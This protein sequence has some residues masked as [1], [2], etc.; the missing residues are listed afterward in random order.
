MSTLTAC[1][2]KAGKNISR[3][4]REL[5]L[6]KTQEYRQQGMTWQPAAERAIDDAIERVQALIR[7]SRE[8]ATQEPEAAPPVAAPAPEKAKPEVSANKV[9]TDDAAARARA[10]LKSKLSTPMGGIDPEILQAGIVLA[11]YHIEKGARTFAAYARAMLDDMGEGI[12]PYLKQFYMATKYDPRAGDIAKEMSSA[13]FVEEFD[14]AAIAAP[15]TAEPEQ[16]GAQDGTATRDL[17]SAGTAE[18]AGQPAADVRAPAG[19]RDAG[20]VA[21]GSG[22]GTEPRDADADA[23]GDDLGGSLGTGEPGAVSGERGAGGR[24]A[25]ERGLQGAPRADSGNERADDAGREAGLGRAGHRLQGAVRQEDAPE[26]GLAQPAAAPNAAPIAPPQITP[27][28][29]QDFT[30]G[31]D[32]ELGEGGQKTKFRANLAA[33][34]LAK[35]LRENPERPITADDQRT[36]AKYVGWGGLPQAFDANNPDWRKEHAELKAALTPE[37]FEDARRSTRYAHY[38]SREII[39]DGVYAAL[40]HFGF[41]GGRVLEPGAGVGNFIGMMPADMRTAG[42][43]TAI[44]REPIAVTIAKHLYPQQNVQEA[45]FTQF[46]GNDGY[47][48]AVVGNPPFASDTQVD[49]SRRK[50]LSGLNLHSYFF[51][52][53]VDMM[54]EGGVLAQVVTNYFLDTTGDKARK[55][56]ADRTKFLGAIRLP[57]NAFSKNAGT[58]VTTD[59]IFLQKRP[60]SEWGSK[61]AKDEAK[62]W[63]D[64][65]PYQGEGGDAVPL[66]TYFHEHPEMMLG[67]FGGYGTM[68]RKGSP[69]LIAREGQDTL[70]LLKEAVAKLPAGVYKSI[71]ETGSA[72]AIDRAVVAL[73]KP[74][75]QEGGYFVKDGK[76]MQ[77]LQDLAGEARGVELTADTQWTEKTK[78]GERRLEQIRQLADL[79]Q[80]L[81]DLL[82]AELKGD[83]RME[84]LR[85]TLNAQYDAYR[86]DHGLLGD[87]A[88]YQVFDDDPD[89]PLL[90]SLEHKYAAGI[91]PADAKKLGIKPTKSTAEKA[92]IF[93]RRVVEAREQVRKVESPKDALAVSMAERGRLDT[94]YI[95]ELLGKD[96]QDV[97]QEMTQ[98][99][100][101]LLFM[102]PATNEYVLRDAYLSGNVRAKLAQAKAAAMTV[103]ARELEKV[104]PEDVPAHQIAARIGAPWVPT[105]VYENFAKDLFGEGTKASITY[106]QLNSSYGVYVTAGSEVN[107]S[108]K[109]GIPAYS[110]PELLAALLNNRT[111]KVTYK[112]T[113]GKTHTDVEKTEMANQKAQEIKDRFNDWLM[114]DPDR[115][116]LLTRAY[117]DTNNNY[118]T[119]TYDGS[120]MTFPGKVPDS[121]VKFRRHQRNAIARIVQDRTVLLDH[122]VGAGKTFEIVAAAMELKRT[123]LANKPLVAVPN[124]LVKQWAADF[125]RLYPGANILTATKKDFERVN[126]RRFLAKI[127]TG[128]WDAVVIAHSSF[129][130]IQPGADF[131][132]AFNQKQIELIAAAIQEVEESDADDKAKKRTVK[133]LE[134]MME[135]LEKR[136]QRLRD[137]PMD[138]LLDFHELG[139]DQLFVDEAHMFKNLMYQTKLQNVAGLGDP[140]GSKRAYDMYVKTQEVMEKNGRGQGLVFATG[141]PVSNSLAEKYHMMRYLMPEQMEELGFQSFDAWANT[142]ADVRQHWMQ[143]VSGDGFKA[144]NRMSEFVNVHELLKLFDQVADT[145]TN[146]DIK[147]AYREEN[148]GAEY[149]LPPIKGGK[150]RAPVSLDKSPRQEA[151]MVQLAARAA[152]VEARKGPPQKG[153]DN[154]LSLMTDARKA[155]MDIRLVDLDVTEREKG[156]RIDKSAGEIAA[157]Y[158]QWDHVKGTQLVFSDLGTP[159]KHAEKELKEYQRLQAIVAE[160]SDEVRDRAA[161]GD[162]RAQEI[163]NAAEDAE[164]ELDEQGPDWIT[165]V[166]AA[167]RGFSVYDDLKDALVE[168]GIPEGQIAFIHDYNTDDQKAALFRKVNA[169]DIRVVIGSTPKM[170]AGTN[171]QERLVALHH[172]DVPWR[173][174]DVEQREGRIV[175]QGNL[176]LSQVPG[177]EVEV[178]AYVTKDTLD[179]RMWQ[180]QEVKLKIINQLRTR[181]I[182]RNIDNAFEDME[183]SASE[184]QAAATGNMDLLYEIQ[185]RNDIKKLENKRRSFEAQKNDLIGRKRKTEAELQRLPKEIA[186]EEKLKVAGDEYRAELASAADSFKVTIDGK[187]Y[188]DWREASTYLLAKTDAKQYTRTVEKDGKK[189]REEQTAEEHAALADK[190]AAL[191]KEGKADDDKEVAALTTELTSWTERAAPLDI[192]MNGEQYTARAKLAEAFSNIRGDR[193][194]ISW[195]LNGEKINRSVAAAT[196]VRQ[197]VTDALADE[198][199]AS[200]GTLGPFTVT[201]EGQPK[202][203]FGNKA[204]DI[205]L[206]AGGEKIDGYITAGEDLMKNTLEVAQRVVDFANRRA[207]DAGSS[208]DFLTRRLESVKKQKADLDSADALGEWPEQ[209]KLEDAR[210]KHAEILKR[211]ASGKAADKPAMFQGE[212]SATGRKVGE[213]QQAMDAIV[214]EWQRTMPITVVS[215]IE[216]PSVPMAVRVDGAERVRRG[217]GTPKAVIYGGHVFLFANAIRNEAEATTIVYHEVL[218]HAGMRGLFGREFDQILNQV[219]LLRREDVRRMI[220][221]TGMDPA[222]PESRIRA[223]EE[224]LAYLAQEKPELPLVQRVLAA[225]RSFLRNLPF[226]KDM[227]LSDAELIRDFI[228]PARRFVEGGGPGGGGQRQDA[229]FAQGFNSREIQVDGQWRPVDNSNGQLIAGHD[230]DAQQAFWRWFGDSKV[231]DTE[232]KPLVVYHGTDASFSEFQP[233]KNGLIFVTPKPDF[234]AKFANRYA[235]ELAGGENIMPVYAQANRPLDPTVEADRRAVIDR[236]MEMHP[237]YTMGDGQQALI[238][239]GRKTLYTEKVLE[240]TLKD[241]QSNWAFLEQESILDAIERVGFDSVYVIEDGVKNLALFEP[242]QLKSATGNRGT[243]DSAN[244]NI[245][246]SQDAGLNQPRDFWTLS[247]EAVAEMAEGSPGKLHWWHK[248]LGTQYNLAKRSPLFKRVFDH[249]QDFLE[250]VSLYATEAADKA[251]SILPKLDTWR[252]IMPKPLGGSGKKPLSA[253]DNKA[254]RAPIFEG[255]L[256]WTRDAFGNPIRIDDMMARAKLMT[257]DEKAQQMVKNNQLS[258]NVLRMWR[259]LPHEQFDAMVN[260]R[261]ENTALKAGI[262]WTRTELGNLFDLTEKQ[263]D[264][265]AEFR[266][267]VDESITRAALADMVRLVGKDADFIRDEVMQAKDVKDG[268]DMLANQLDQLAKD[269]PD[270]S[271]G[272]AKTKDQLEDKARR[273]LELMDKGYAPLMRFG[274]YTVTVYGANEDTGEEEVKFFGMYESGVQARLAQKALSEDFGKDATRIE[275][276]TMN[277]ESYKL[278]SGINPETVELFGEMLGMSAT[279]DS[280]TDQAF[281]AYLKLARNNRSAMKRMI[282]RKGTAGFSE[283]VGRVLAGFT[284]STARMTSRNLHTGQIAEAVRDIQLKDKNQGELA[285]QATRLMDY[286]N[287]P[288][289][290][291]QALRG[292]LFA[293]YLGGSIAAALVNM[294]QPFQVTMPYL[295]QYGGIGKSVG[296]MRWALANAWKE[297]TG[298][299]DLDRDMKRAVE[300]GV[301]APQEVHQLMAQARG[302]G[303]LSAGDGTATG[304]AIATTM[305]FGRRLAAAWGMPF[306]TAE[307]F[308]RRV[309]FAA[310]YRTAKEQGI[311]NPFEFAKTTV[312]DTQFLYNKGNRPE[313]ARGALGAT[314]MT[315]KTYSISYLELVTRMWMAGEPGSPERA[316]GRRAVFFAAGMILLM[317]GAG[318]FPFVEDVEDVIDGVMQRLGYNWQSKQKVRELLQEA[319]GKAFGGFLEKGVSGFPGAPIDVSGRLGM[320]NLI[321]ATGLFQKKKDHSRDVLEVAGP[322]GDLA[323]RAGKGVDAAGDGDL[324]EAARQ[325]VPKA[326]RDFS[327]MVQMLS[328]GQYK[329]ERGDKVIDTTTADAIFKGIGFQPGD[330]AQAQ[331]ADSAAQSMVALARMR[332]SEIAAKW[333][334]GLAERDQAAQQ[335]ARRDLAAWNEKNPNTPIRIRFQDILRRANTMNLSRSQRIEKSAPKEVRQ[336][337]GRIMRTSNGE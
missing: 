102:D 198:K 35:E 9:F 243:F 83:A 168:R 333:A 176:L 270:R 28:Q 25:G 226:L 335:E 143:K 54:R 148:D 123:G 240:E 104:Q 165:A 205:V 211:L 139:V 146:D 126:R 98:G 163:V 124:H 315:F 336:E 204:L 188:S 94:A 51:A 256:E 180:I 135:R 264:L 40:R 328:T 160:A 159:K 239:N 312:I 330:V 227:Q 147:K 129:G 65:R 41:T 92:P 134:G 326:M 164:K 278:F 259:G 241:E 282:H 149:P 316:A 38:T 145:V 50:H 118:V 2:N 279:G 332:E 195:T 21:D 302:V 43:I 42:R 33:I 37:E 150:P 14:V 18:P 269:D 56:I 29:L 60:E 101:P 271:S 144:Q 321:P 237:Q 202:D 281:Q 322:T 200:I 257:A 96:P 283:D 317:G 289:E 86:K 157:R 91:G 288:A 277:E 253:E 318:G 170:G 182:E 304:N 331:Q 247:K 220:E 71:A 16:N 19:E 221:K 231:V 161:L 166:K 249:V 6:A 310:A 1:L 79:R 329:N 255:T 158:K 116:E 109:W 193:T 57:N 246:F 307:L 234:A 105:E 236:L 175:R 152:I 233:D 303:G 17:D 55:Y 287:N 81:R 11:G 74:P 171:V 121:V 137:K 133:Q 95:G 141:T 194:P 209:G 22:R 53:S 113:E 238:V 325:V 208:L 130:F 261:F 23:A 24:D 103:N 258:P 64:V 111:I 73:E 76:V 213:L 13:A 151:Y 4:D 305:N 334:K 311:A 301:V 235:G 89:F 223:A 140:A 230:R 52:K 155:A 260:S 70:A 265:Y 26:R 15:K 295:S 266:A 173:P 262:R 107:A 62:A 80:T 297:N 219:A 186:V 142:Y 250:D 273:A 285:R 210:K 263:K 245:A 179:M 154:Q 272:M 59:I 115:A 106:Q 298:D 207:T 48:D 252:D 196:A 324:M 69:A 292:L 189:V 97:L 112:D 275:R 136:I 119:R 284:Y 5:I 99:D 187:E 218:G 122:V 192:T 67:K 244:P 268:M 153:E 31:D 131:E 267:S 320:G 306:S 229:A 49:Q 125:Y 199:E 167:L 197:L 313:W 215:S 61:L 190:L 225:I 299:A 93:N 214:D 84:S 323:A 296:R 309:T 32:L 90:L 228:L 63:M 68:Y 206:Q 290:E 216:S 183:M 232:G 181:Q 46:M 117:N 201:V 174:S 45:D 34:Q 100:E 108:N 58:E 78:L 291:A 88:T 138:D 169:G 30:I 327:K 319:F 314:L 300:E 10:V 127:A 162:E 177:F 27:Q 120:W 286:V 337:A 87:R 114:A 217:G 224:V 172:L 254:I 185:A 156:G 39:Q 242:T 7:Q 12:R 248:T 8:G 82:A 308:N 128:D 191:R 20:D 280:A 294:T 203:K 3:E 212:A 293:Q 132:A 85:K 184:M 72:E 276:G 44:E 178:L 222:D 77:R 251:P 47:F 274:H 36:L 110:G 75:V 66:N